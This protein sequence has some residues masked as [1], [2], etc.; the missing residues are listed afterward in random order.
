MIRIMD[1]GYC[2]Y[3]TK[4]GVFDYSVSNFEG[5]TYVTKNRVRLR[6]NSNR[7]CYSILKVYHL[8]K[9]RSISKSVFYFDDS[10]KIIKEIKAEG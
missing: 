4:K 7:K 5:W 8:G 6:D 10:L 2:S 3:E 9:L 1:G